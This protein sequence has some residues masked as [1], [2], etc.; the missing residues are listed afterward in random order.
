VAAASL[1][2][3]RGIGEGACTKTGVDMDDR[4]CGLSEAS[5]SPGEALFDVPGDALWLAIEI[6]SLVVCLEAV[7]HAPRQA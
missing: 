1:G 4:R 3:Q 2:A 7:V 5:A 6:L